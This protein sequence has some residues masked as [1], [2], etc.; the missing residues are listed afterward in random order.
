MSLKPLV[1]V[2]QAAPFA[3][4]AHARTDTNVHA[5]EPRARLRTVVLHR[6]GQNLKSA[7]TEP[8]LSRADPKH[9]S[10]DDS[11]AQ[12]LALPPSGARSSYSISAAATHSFGTNGIPTGRPHCSGGN[13]DSRSVKTTSPVS[14]LP[15]G[16]PPPTI[17]RKADRPHWH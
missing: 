16:H 8:I 6:L 5:L 12:A 11:L 17:T 14:R 2:R 7:I 9:A 3:A 4:A 13:F 15:T 1:V 10:N